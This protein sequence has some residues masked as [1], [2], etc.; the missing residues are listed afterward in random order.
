VPPVH[1]H[2]VEGTP[3]M[4]IQFNEEDVF[5]SA[6]DRDSEPGSVAVLFVSAQ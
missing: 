2:E 6:Q 4:P 1:M 5:Q 3:A